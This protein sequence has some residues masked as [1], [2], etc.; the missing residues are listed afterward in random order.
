MPEDIHS[1][2]RWFWVRTPSHVYAPAKQVSSGGTYQLLSGETI[3]L[4]EADVVEPILGD[5]ERLISNDVPD[6]VQMAHVSEAA[7]LHNIRLRASQDRYFTNIGSIL[8]SVNPFKWLDNLYS[9]ETAAAYKSRR[10][11]ESSVGIF[12]CIADAALAGFIACHE[13]IWRVEA[14]HLLSKSGRLVGVA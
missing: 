11:G 4:L 2:D 5:A 6:M 9:K 12:G 3:Q 8:V 13:W 7:V 14:M 10:P 1:G